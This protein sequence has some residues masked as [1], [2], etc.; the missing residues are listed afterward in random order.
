[1]KNCPTDGLPFN[2]RDHCGDHCAERNT[3]LGDGLGDVVVMYDLKFA[4][5]AVDQLL[6]RDLKCFGDFVQSIYIGLGLAAFPILHRLTRDRQFFCKIILRQLLLL[7]VFF[8]VFSDHKI[9]L[10]DLLLQL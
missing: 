6:D 1:M 4:P 9:I 3:A 7:A 5:L 2:V 8:D 10:P